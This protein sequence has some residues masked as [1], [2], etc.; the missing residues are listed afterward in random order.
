MS[1]SQTYKS[2]TIAAWLALLLG[3][4]GVHRLY[5]Y[6]THDKLAWLHP[7]PMMLGVYGLQG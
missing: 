6:G 5:L 1:E 3:G 7:I 2:K 4:F